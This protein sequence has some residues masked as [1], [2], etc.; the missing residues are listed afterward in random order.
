MTD[1][2]SNINVPVNGT[3]VNK[4]TS[5]AK[6]TGTT[7]TATGAGASPS[8]EVGQVDIASAQTLEKIRESLAAQPV[9]DRLKVESVK[10]ALQ[11]GTYQIN[12][13]NIAAKLIE[14]EKLI[15]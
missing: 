11:D 10:Q 5:G 1:K 15:K 13:E 14:F 12:S 4:S 7:P 2:I 8:S 9:V 6:G 3:S